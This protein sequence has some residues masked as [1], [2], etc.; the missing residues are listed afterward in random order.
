M[1]VLE[2]NMHVKPT[3][4]RHL[5]WLA[6]GTPGACP[7]ELHNLTWEIKYMQRNKNEITQRFLFLKVGRLG[8]SYLVFNSRRQLS[9]VNTGDYVNSGKQA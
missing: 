8:F 3:L 4:Y 7:Q 6:S 9:N 1:C 2:W 5:F